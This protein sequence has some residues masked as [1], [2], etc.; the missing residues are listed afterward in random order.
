[1]A[2]LGHEDLRNV[3]SVLAQRLDSLNIDYAIMGGAAT[4]LL[5]P[6]PS[7]RTQDV[8]LVIHVDH[9]KITAD[10]LTSTLLTSF[11]A[12]FEG[13][14]QFGHVIPAYRLHRPGA[15][16]QL[17]ELEVFD[18]SSWPQR[19]QYNLSTA[20]RKML[21]INDQVVKLFSPEWI[22]REKILS[23]Y[24]RQGSAK[25][26]N[27]IRDIITMIPLTTP[28]IPE[29]DFN[30]NQ[31]CQMALGNLLQKRPALV[32]TLKAKIKCRTIFQN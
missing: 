20:T 28:G 18:Y 13:V 22:L 27:D 10:R 15:A 23:Q 6:D 8:D 32:Q 1:M 26:A 31:E 7:R 14:N 25:E 30:E 11:S 19:P 9:R 17:V 24:Q 12:E 4:C 16:T 29:L 3:V 21:R 5:S 2:P